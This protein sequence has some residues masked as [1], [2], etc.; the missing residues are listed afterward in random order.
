M[1]TP[2][3]DLLRKVQELAAISPQLIE[4]ATLLLKNAATRPKR[5]N[6]ELTD[7]DQADKRVKAG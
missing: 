3:P 2:Q 4:I 5:G 7:G 6:D 1:L